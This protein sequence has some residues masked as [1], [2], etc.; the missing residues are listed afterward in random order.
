MSN[1]AHNFTTTVGRL[2][3]GD[4]FLGRDKDL[5]GR[6]LT[7]SDGKPRVEFVVVVAFPKTDPKTEELRGEIYRAGMEGFPAH[8]PNGQCTLPTFS[9]KWTDGDSQ[10]PNQRGTKPCDKEGYP[11]NWVITFKGSFAPKVYNANNEQILDP[12]AVKRGDYVRVAGSARANGKQTKPGVYVNH[13]LIQ[14]CGYGEEISSG[15]DAATAFAAPAHLPAGASATPVAPSGG[16]PAPDGVPMPAPAGVPT[17]GSAPA[18]MPG[19]GAVPQGVPAN[20][21][22][23]IAPAPLAPPPPAAAPPVKTTKPGCPHT[24]EQ[25]VAAGWNDEQMRAAGHLA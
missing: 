25:L 15:P 6:P 8:F 13:S 19:F 9:F 21:A 11:G 5:E 3:G 2:V 17:P 14:L 12:K 22:P 24:Y 23:P 16:M 1:N 4:L 7:T 20:G 10:V 18:P